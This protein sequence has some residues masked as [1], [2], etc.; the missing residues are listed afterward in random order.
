M[1]ILLLSN[2]SHLLLALKQLHHY[3]SLSKFVQL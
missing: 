3:Y 2:E 1:E